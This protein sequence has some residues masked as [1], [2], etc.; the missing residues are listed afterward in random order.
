LNK[1]LKQK[2]QVPKSYVENNNMKS[3]SLIFNLC[4]ISL[5]LPATGFADEFH[6]NYPDVEQDQLV[7]Y[8]KQQR[9]KKHIDK[10]QLEVY[11][12]RKVTQQNASAESVNSFFNEAKVDTSKMDQLD[13]DMLFRALKSWELQKV[14]SNFE[15]KVSKE[16]IK[17]AW[18]LRRK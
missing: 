15:G 9:L 2:S 12:A 8:L 13:K 17:R 6:V 5:L 14:I 18:K 16:S 11:G 3:K 10:G 1:K 4:L 7:P